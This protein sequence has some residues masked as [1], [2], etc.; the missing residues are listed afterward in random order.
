MT[1]PRAPREETP[2]EERS[3]AIDRPP[4]DDPPDVQAEGTVPG[5]TVTGDLI[6]CPWCGT[7]NDIYLEP[8]DQTSVS[9]FVEE[10]VECGRDFELTAEFEPSGIVRLHATRPE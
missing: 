5:Q 8:S 2:G 4:Q 10:C 7:G 9:E 1:A 3:G 6:Q